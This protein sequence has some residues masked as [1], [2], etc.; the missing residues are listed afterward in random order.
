M[1]TKLFVASIIVS[2]FL[3]S[4]AETE[5]PRQLKI[6]VMPAVD[7]APIYAALDE[8]LYAKEGL[9][10]EITL[11]TNAQNRQTALQANQIDGA[12]TDLV[13]LITNVNSGFPIRGT[14]STDGLFPLLINGELP[15]D[16]ELSVGMMEISVSNYLVEQYLGG[17]YSLEKV[18]INEIP[19]RLEA[20]MSDQLKAGLF[21]EPIASVGEMRGLQKVFFPGI[22]RQSLDIMAFTQKALKE[23]KREIQA[24]H[25]AYGEAVKLLSAD[26]DL[27][28]KTLATHIP[29][30]PPTLGD[31]ISL[32]EYSAPGLP[33]DEF[34]DEIIQWTARITG[35]EIPIGPGDIL[36]RSFVE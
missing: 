32:P 29:N 15:K 36:D 6:G 16:G 34:I 21:P 31:T 2:F 18:F 33:E 22:P 24:F 12:M 9:D 19:A 23:K 11:F 4:C 5:E 26:A 10:V 17:D 25:R 30:L 8:G 7:I 27:G 1:K 20:V 3:F 28:W 14:L 35:K 13:A